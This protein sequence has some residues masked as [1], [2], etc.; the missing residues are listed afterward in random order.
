M[1]TKRSRSVVQ[2]DHSGSTFD[3][4]LEAE[5]IREEVD[6][7][8]LKRILAW[9]FQQAMRKQRTTKKSMAERPVP[10]R[11]QLDSKSAL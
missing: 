3:S 2:I 9:Q 8:A 4:F 1:R 10:T 5:G 6:A 11:S 7:V